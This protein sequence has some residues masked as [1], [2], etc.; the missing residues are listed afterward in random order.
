MTR[1]QLFLIL[2]VLI[3]GS[4]ITYLFV[5]APP[6]EIEKNSEE[7]KRYGYEDLFRILAR[8][9]DETRTL[10][11]NHI[12]QKGKASG[13]NFDEHWKEKDVEAGPLPALFL[14]ETSGY[15]EKSQIDLG[16]F[17]GSDFPISTAN[18]FK[19]IQKSKFEALKKDKKPK[20]FSDEESGRNYAMF[21]DYAV[22]AA[23]V[24]CHNEHKDSP[25]IDWK[26]GDIMGATT[27]STKIDSLTTDEMINY[28]NNYLEASVKTYDKFL[29]E[30]RNFEI[31]ESPKIGAQ[32]PEE[33]YY[34]PS[35]E[36]FVSKLQT[37]YAPYLLDE[38]L[39]R[40]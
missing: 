2:I 38:I 15:L 13:I 7:K 27:W 37:L 10:Y 32:W 33:G 5:S 40:K 24:N 29:E 21:P 16:L 28:V 22:G 36:E 12:V 3:F 25:K 31:N 6:S 39:K 8:I 4:I 35:K 1:K 14:R 9:N 19:G 26:L 30:L 17:L 23:C 11:T 34:I 20:F 18:K